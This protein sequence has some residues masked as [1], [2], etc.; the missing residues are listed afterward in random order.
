MGA[1]DRRKAAT[2]TIRNDVGTSTETMSPMV[3]TRRTP[4]C[5]VRSAILRRLR[6]DLKRFEIL[7]EMGPACCALTLRSSL[8]RLSPS[9]SWNNRTEVSTEAMDPTPR[10]RTGPSGFWRGQRRR[11]GSVFSESALTFRL[12]FPAINHQ[13]AKHTTFY[14]PIV[15]AWSST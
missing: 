15:N 4:R 2:G 14:F 10:I 5:F 6:P 3:P 13:L 9:A 1:P 7:P 12:A 8:P 11:G